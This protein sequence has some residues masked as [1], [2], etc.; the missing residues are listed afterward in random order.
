MTPPDT[1]AVILDLIEKA[2]K[3]TPQGPW[4]TD[5]DSRRDGADQIVYQ[6]ADGRHLTL[7]FMAS[8]ANVG[9]Y[10]RVSYLAACSPSA[11]LPLLALALKGLDAEEPMD[12]EACNGTGEV[13]FVVE[14][15]PS[16]ATGGMSELSGIKPCDVC[17]GLGE[18]P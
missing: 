12:C 2:Q 3:V 1:R 5:Y 14:C 7:C 9:S 10:D 17:N 8:G 13:E 6:H 15:S 16:E 18:Q 4:Y 11:L